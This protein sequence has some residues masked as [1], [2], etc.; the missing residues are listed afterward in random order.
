MTEHRLG[1]I[2]THGQL[3][4]QCELCD[5]DAEIERL[6]AGSGGFLQPSRLKKKRPEA[7]APGRE[8]RQLAN[9]RQPMQRGPAG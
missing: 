2:C 3:A 8:A 6:R 5:R 9:R 7:K 1:A 4:R